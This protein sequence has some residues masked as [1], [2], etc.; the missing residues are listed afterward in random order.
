LN[1]NKN[2]TEPDSNKLDHRERSRE[3]EFKLEDKLIKE[4]EKIKKQWDSS[5]NFTED[6]NFKFMKL[7]GGFKGV[8]S[9]QVAKD[10]KKDDDEIE[11]IDS[12]KIGKFKEM[13]E[14]LEKQFHIGKAMQRSW[15]KGGLGFSG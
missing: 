10:L 3:K 5:N 11:V 2:T 6:Q 4:Q 12:E 13:D 8:E 7:M 15:G 9:H 1:K 14:V